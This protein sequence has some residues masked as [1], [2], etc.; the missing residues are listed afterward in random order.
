VKAA[1][2]DVF[3][4]AADEQR[5]GKR[6][7]DPKRFVSIAPTMAPT[8]QAHVLTVKA[9]QPV[10]LHRATTQIARQVDGQSPPV[11]VG[12]LDPHVPRQASN[13]I[14][15]RLDLGVIQIGRQFEPPRSTSQRICAT[16]RSRNASRSAGPHTR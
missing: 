5:G 11:R 10:V 14:E 12:L 1:R 7:G 3:E 15:Q 13:S 9:T 4:Q 2:R 8:A 6:S 16:K